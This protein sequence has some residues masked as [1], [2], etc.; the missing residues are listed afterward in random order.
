MRPG[1]FTVGLCLL[2]LLLSSFTRS[3]LPKESDPGRTHVALS[4]TAS[5]EE[6]FEFCGE[7]D[8]GHGGA[9]NLALNTDATR[10]YVVSEGSWLDILDITNP[11]QIR[12]VAQRQFDDMPYGDGANCGIDYDP[13]SERIVVGG[14]PGTKIFLIDVTNDEFRLLDSA[15]PPNLQFPGI[16]FPSLLTTPPIFVKRGSM[17]IGALKTGGDAYDPSRGE[18]VYFGE[19]I[20]VLSIDPVRRKMSVV[21]EG[22]GGSSTIYGELYDQGRDLLLCGGQDG[23]EAI[24]DFSQIPSEPFRYWS[25]CS[26]DWRSRVSPDVLTR[27][28]KWLVQRVAS[29][30]PADHWFVRIR[31]VEAA[32]G[33]YSLWSA[34]MP[35]DGAPPCLV[36][37]PINWNGD[38]EDPGSRISSRPLLPCVLTHD[39]AHLITAELGGNELL[40]L[41]LADKTAE[42]QVL[43]T[44]TIEGGEQIQSI[45]GYR[46]RFYISLKSGKVVVYQWDFVPKPDPPWDLSASVSPGGQSV[47]LSWRPPF[48]G[49]LP[50]GYN[51]YRRTGSQP[52]QKVAS[53]A[54]ATWT[55]EST[56]EGKTYIYIVR[57]FAPAY[58]PI[59]S[60]PSP[61]VETTAPTGIPPKKVSALFAEP[62]LGGVALDWNPNPE[63]DVSGYFIYRKT[64]D[65]PFVKI[66]P[67]RVSEARYLDVNLSDA[68]NSSYYVTAADAHLEGP[69]SETVACVPGDRTP[70]LLLNPDAE[71]Q[72]LRHWTN[73]SSAFSPD[74]ANRY[75]FDNDLFI[76]VTSGWSSHGQWAFWA[77]QTSGRFDRET[78]SPM[79]ES[80]LLA[81]YQ[82]VDVSAFSE[83]IDSPD[84]DIVAEWGGHAIRT[85]QTQNIVASI[86]IEFLDAGK[87]LLERRQLYTG[88]TGEWME[89]S[90]KNHVPAGTRSVRFSMLARDA[91][92]TPADAAW[93]DLWLVLRE[94]KPPPP[95]QLAVSVGA[96][97][98]AVAFGPTTQGVFYQIEYAADGLSE[99]TQWKPCGPTFL[100]DGNSVQWLDSPDEQTNPTTPP[101]SIVNRRFYRVRQD[102]LALP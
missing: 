94:E 83:A 70:N 65:S 69:P 8:P 43:F 20:Y 54:E 49:V 87:S 86:A 71:E 42:P 45:K 31:Q 72:S 11:L 75:S 62:T 60:D 22:I 6:R 4:P 77:D 46:N 10:L 89:L 29:M 24:L 82:D 84:K 7:F 97:A 48:G 23:A 51:I 95:L 59:E 63:T 74:P 100:G 25:R 3:A 21:D 78:N 88:V 12:S 102:W 17:I 61:E 1:L 9:Y 79:N 93:D 58:G 33:S 13:Y 57:S 99:T 101:A 41:D 81:A 15:Y 91:S 16:Q 67:S 55:D 18:K 56:A 19:G 28:G 27:D 76:A 47:I 30:H 14:G 38:T 34:D 52:F 36:G 40:V 39:E 85:S 32:A 35:S 68:A 64:G 80:Y 44:T 98:I 96:S 26:G 66:T 90:S 92:T 73:A 37:S 2:A 5:H 53:V 50:V